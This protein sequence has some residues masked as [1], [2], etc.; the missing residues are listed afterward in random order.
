MICDDTFLIFCIVWRGK[1][2]CKIDRLDSIAQ[3]MLDIALNP[4]STLATTFCEEITKEPN[5]Y[6][7]A[8]PGTSRNDWEN[9]TFSVYGHDKELVVFLRPDEAADFAR[10]HGSTLDDGAPLIIEVSRVNLVPKVVEYCAS[11]Q[12]KFLKIYSRSPLSI[13]CPISV[14]MGEELKQIQSDRG[15]NLRQ[16]KQGSSFLLVDE[17]KDTLNTYNNADRREMDP[18]G[19]YENI[20]SLV[21]AVIRANQINSDEVDH[22]LDL[23]AGYTKH[24]CIERASCESSKATIKKYLNYFG[25]SEYLYLFKASSLELINEIRKNP[26]LDTYTLKPAKISTKEKFK[27]LSFRRGHDYNDAFVYGLQLQSKKRLF[28]LVV[29]LPFGL[30]VGKEYEIVGLEPEIDETKLDSAA[31]AIPLP[32]ENMQEELLKKLENKDRKIKKDPKK[33]EPEYEE[34]RKSFII[35]DFKKQ[36]MNFP[37]AEK[38]FQALAVEPDILDEYYLY[39]KNRRFGKIEILGYTLR[40]LVKELHFPAY[41]ASLQMVELRKDP[42]ETAQRL[43]YRETDPQ[44]TAM[45]TK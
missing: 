14:F 39:L 4:D 16:E 37:A 15:T 5:Y 41:E 42:K 17:I 2:G 6:L 43:K 9:K 38:S 28:D 1:E 21:E 3:S 26:Q 12:V 29:S 31:D 19:H 25:L 22:L 24:F 13:L 7:I 10:R 33:G 11:G 34:H 23:P 8:E 30:S 20:H 45:K 32:S 35:G 18:S 27:L 40:R 44:Y 36:G